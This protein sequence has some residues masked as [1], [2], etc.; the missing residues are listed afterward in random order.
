[1][2]RTQAVLG[3]HQVRALPVDAHGL[4]RETHHTL[5]F[6]LYLAAQP[7]IPLAELGKD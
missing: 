5:V 6:N 7:R 3:I 1:M 2:N 4:T